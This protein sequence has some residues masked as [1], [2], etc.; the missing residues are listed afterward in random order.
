MRLRLLA[1]T[2]SSTL[3]TTTAVAQ[4]PSAQLIVTG[5]SA[6]DVRGVTSSAITAAPSLAVAWPQATVRLG[7]SG[8]RFTTGSWALGGDA[9]IGVRAPIASSPLAFTLDAAAG[10]TTTSYRAHFASVGAIPAAELAL[11][12]VAVFGG[13][14]AAQAWTTLAPFA[15]FGP[16]FGATTT[17]R[18]S[19]GLV[20]GARV[21]LASFGRSD[22]ITLGY[23]EEHAR[24][25]RVGVADRAGTFTFARGP[26]ALTGFLG[27]RRAPD[28]QGTFGG[29]S[30]TIALS[31]VVAFQVGAQRYPS[32]RLTGAL[33]GSAVNAGFVLRTPSGPRP[34]LEPSGVRAPAPGFTR[35]AI[36]A[37]A[38]RSVDVAGDWNGWQPVSATRA[39]NGVWYADIAVPPGE[40]RYAFRIDGKQ[41]R[42]PDGV[43]ATDDGLGGKSAWLSVRQPAQ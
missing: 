12:R 16:A 20:F 4:S 6:T 29:A 13:V 2:I 35:L 11:A 36:R 42:V 39:G 23:R 3:Y 17:A 34:R 26:V 19:L 32:D 15:P 5:G 43:I 22:G 41:W 24:V 38:A 37:P 9:S 21:L 28:E 10:A 33:G 25:H 30:A 14:R 8:T 18:S 40:Y 27:V 31:R 7:A 1:L